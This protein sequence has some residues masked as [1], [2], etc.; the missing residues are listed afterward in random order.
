MPNWSTVHVL[1]GS[2]KGLC[3]CHI[4]LE[5]LLGNRLDEAAW[6]RIST[7]KTVAM[8]LSW[9]R[10]ECSLWVREKVLSQVEQFKYSRILFMFEGKLEPEMVKQIGTASVA[11]WV[12]Y[13]SAGWAQP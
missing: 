3:L 1:C 13:R 5:V 9:K 2:G 12:L 10:V 7:F 11:I 8:V 6:M 4:L